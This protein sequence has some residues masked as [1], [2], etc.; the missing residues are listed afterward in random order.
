MGNPLIDAE[1][2]LAD[3]RE[4]AEWQERLAR[5]RAELGRSPA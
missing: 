5:E 1:F 4:T 3:E 2:L